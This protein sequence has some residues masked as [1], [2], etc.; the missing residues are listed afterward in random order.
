MPH[1]STDSIWPLRVMQPSRTVWQALPTAKFQWG[2]QVII[3]QVIVG[4]D[5]EMCLYF[6]LLYSMTHDQYYCFA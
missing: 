6:L 5:L 2:E 3:M 1:F 4:F